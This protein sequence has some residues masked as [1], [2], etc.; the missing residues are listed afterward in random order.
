MLIQPCLS[1]WYKRKGIPES[2]LCVCVSSLALCFRLRHSNMCSVLVLGNIWVIWPFI[3]LQYNIDALRTSESLRSDT[4]RFC[5]HF[6]NSQHIFTVA[7]F[8]NNLKER[9]SWFLNLRVGECVHV[10]EGDVNQTILTPVCND[11]SCKM[12]Y[13]QWQCHTPRSFRVE[14]IAQMIRGGCATNFGV[15]SVWFPQ[16][17]YELV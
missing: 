11:E 15:A 2:A 17:I 14:T 8:E 12:V 5:T 13:Y 4:S 6:S 1:D 10:R 9:A 7:F 3:F 16:K